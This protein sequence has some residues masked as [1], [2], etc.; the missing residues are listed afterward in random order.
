[1]VM[2]RVDVCWEGFMPTCISCTL[3][4]RLKWP[5]PDCLP[6][7]QFYKVQCL[8]IR[9][10]KIPSFT[11]CALGI[12]E[13]RAAMPLCELKSAVWFV[14]RHKRDE[15]RL[16]LMERKTQ[17][18]SRNKA[19]QVWSAP[20]YVVWS[21]YLTVFETICFFGCPILNGILWGKG[22]KKTKKHINL[23]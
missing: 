2:F 7:V 16:A 17:S 8:A 5:D 1:M 20:V 18:Q 9:R 10:V 22:N 14:Q 6:L 15:R 12:A 13:R 21:L 3:L 23:P 11:F 4:Q 19:R